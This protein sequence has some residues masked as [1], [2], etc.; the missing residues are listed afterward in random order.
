MK[1][2]NY[3]K[4]CENFGINY[5]AVKNNK[6]NFNCFKKDIRFFGIKNL[7]RIVKGLEL[8]SNNEYRYLYI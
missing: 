5:L 3:K 2:I 1:R 7:A 6:K 4:M 8:V